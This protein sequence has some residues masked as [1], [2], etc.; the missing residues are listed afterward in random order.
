[1]NRIAIVGP[2][3]SGKT[4]LANALKIVLSGV[5]VDEYSREFLSEIGIN[6]KQQ[7]L[8]TIA[9]KQLELIDSA[10]GEYVLADTDV[11]CV[12]IW[13]LF[14]YKSVSEEIEIL[15]KEQ[16]IDRYILCYPDVPWEE[17]PLRENPNDRKELFN[18]FKEELNRQQIPY[19]VVKGPLEKRLKDCFDFIESE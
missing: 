15:L 7:D 3:S 17:D 18:L 12:K 9:K 4:T 1:M 11:T 8:N 2:E 13:S 19:I 10:Q 6:Y 14:K 5:Y 16:K